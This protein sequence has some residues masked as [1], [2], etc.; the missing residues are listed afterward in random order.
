MAA[1]YPAVMSHASPVPT[2]ETGLRSQVVTPITV[3]AG[4]GIGPE[5]MQATLG[6]LEAAGARLRPEPIEVGAA[7][8]ARG[9]SAGID[10]TAWDSLRRTRV[11]LKAPVSTPQGGGF[12]AQRHHPQDARAVRQRPALPRLRAV[13]ADRHPQMDVVIVRE[14]EEDLYA[15]IEHRQ[16]D[17]VVQCLK[18]ISVPTERIV[19]YAFVRAA[20]GPPRSPA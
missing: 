9:A 13:R 10:G 1:F 4:D 5:I 11:F 8:Y 17:D 18:L 6:I 7:A 19:R 14:N 12:K 3:A 2:P 20:D 15:G 16:T